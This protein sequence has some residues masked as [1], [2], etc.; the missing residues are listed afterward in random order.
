MLQD[1]KSKAKHN[2][3]NKFKTLILFLIIT[4]GVLFILQLIFPERSQ[5]GHRAMLDY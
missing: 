5:I 1:E 4:A 2:I 3:K